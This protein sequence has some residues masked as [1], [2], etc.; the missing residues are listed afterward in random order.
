MLCSCVESL[1][2]L[3]RKQLLLRL[4][5]CS[6]LFSLH[7]TRRV[8]LEKVYILLWLWRLLICC[9]EVYVSLDLTMS[10]RLATSLFFQLFLQSFLRFHRRL[11]L[12][13]PLLW[14]LV[15]DFYA[16]YWPLNHRTLS[17]PACRLVIWTAWILAI[18]V[19][20]IY[21][22]PFLSPMSVYS[23]TCFTACF[24]LWHN[25][26]PEH[27]H[28]EKVSAKNCSLT[29]K[30]SHANPAFNESPVNSICC[31]F[32]FFKSFCSK[33]HILKFFMSLASF[34]FFSNSF[35]NSMVYALRTP[36]F[37]Q[38]LNLLCFRRHGE[39]V[40]GRE[41]ERVNIAAADLNNLQLSFE[42][43]VLEDTKLWLEAEVRENKA[44]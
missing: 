27:R 1:S 44:K 28:L 31:H 6:Q 19:S 12:S 13:P 17:T 4:E 32:E 37:K 7:L 34:I 2:S 23:F 15:R 35:V 29:P 40:L 39:M 5:T 36:E 16:I 33:Q 11:P 10:W 3:G 21:V 18:L 43:E 26:R 20:T 8:E 22:L 24:F 41:W 14:Y 30:Q 25:L 9:W 42:Q 38:A